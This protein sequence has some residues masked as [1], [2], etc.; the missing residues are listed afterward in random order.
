M[1][2]FGIKIRVHPTFIWLLVFVLLITGGRTEPMAWL[3]IIFAFVVLHEV[4]H[5]LVARACGIHVHEI[6]LLPIGGVARLGD[7]PEDPRVETRIAIA[8]PLLNFTVAA[9]AWAL[10]MGGLEL[11]RPDGVFTFLGIVFAAN[12][13]LG[14]FNMLP[15]FPMDGGRLLRAW[16]ART[17]SYVEAT[18][19]AASFGRGIAGSM[20]V[21]SLITLFHPEMKWNAWLLLIAAFIYVSGKQEEMS[22]ALRHGLGGLW[23]LFGF[24]RPAAPQDEEPQDVRPP[25]DVIDVEGR[26]IDDTPP[27]QTGQPDSAADAFRRLADDARGRLDQ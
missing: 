19:I 17:R 11:V 27:D 20:V 2:L 1:Q 12:L 8:G 23:R 21:Y 16:L 26:R 15:A 10:H 24:G 3:L 13:G 14:A 22:V 5:C 4:S 9:V 7:V 25:G 18:Q 6:V